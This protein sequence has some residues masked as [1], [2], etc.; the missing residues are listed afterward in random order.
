MGTY[1]P[2]HMHKFV[3]LIY[4]ACGDTVCFRFCFI[5]SGGT[6]L[7]PVSHKTNQQTKWNG[8]NLK[9]GNQQC[10]MTLGLFLFLLKLRFLGRRFSPMQ[11][12][13]YFNQ[14]PNTRTP[15]STFQETP[16]KHFV[17]V[18]VTGCHYLVCLQSQREAGESLPQCTWEMES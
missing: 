2:L 15:F 17:I 18:C 16:Q 3:F 12:S 4:R 1:H 6:C 11:L 8:N 13:L 14:S 10:W 7:P 5:L 9:R